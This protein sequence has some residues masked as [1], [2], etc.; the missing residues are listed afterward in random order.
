VAVKDIVATAGIR[1]TGNS[2]RLIDFVPEVDAAVMQR[3]TA[4]GAVL[5][6]KA[7]TFELAIGGPSTDL[8][9]ALAA[10]PWHPDAYTGGSSS[11]SCV[12]V[13]AGLAMAAIGTDT[14]GSVRNP[15]AHCGVIGLKPTF[16]RISKAGIQPL[17]PQLDHV[18]TITWAVE[19][20]ALMLGPLAGFD[21]ADPTS[22]D[23][24]VPDYAASL[25]TMKDLAGVKIGL[26]DAWYSID[27]VASDDIR[28]AME[29]SAKLLIE[30]GAEVERV[31]LS[32]LADYEATLLV[33][34]LS[35]AFALFGPDL[36]DTP[37][38]FG[39]IFRDRV[40]MGAFLRASDYALAL[41]RK[42]N[43]TVE[44]NVRF[45]EFDILI[46]AGML[47][48]LWLK[49]IPKFAM[50]KGRYLTAPWNVT[51]H[52]AIEVRCGVSSD[53]LPLGLQ[54]AA[55]KFEEETLLSVAHLFERAGGWLVNRQRLLRQSIADQRVL[56][57][58]ST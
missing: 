12:A 52:P 33:M 13:A 17:A 35:D 9:F 53:G 21:P 15:A 47:S 48:S 36:R 42:E 5:L 44:M 37:D 6:G 58:E 16:G 14:G 20:A 39:Q 4:A 28:M 8:P 10:N 54:M 19:D 34:I 29:N 49:D 38:L 22:A 3:L 7:T 31:E 1:T 11:G 40:R 32:P 24:P 43:L 2:R 25:G 56:S 57:R 46:T 18:G 27:P 50:F 55:G 41:E 45:K 23:L 30:L 26:I 51:G